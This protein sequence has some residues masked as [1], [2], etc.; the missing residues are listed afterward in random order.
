MTKHAKVFKNETANKMIN[1]AYE[2]SLSLIK[3]QRTEMMM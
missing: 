3:H 1:D 2:L